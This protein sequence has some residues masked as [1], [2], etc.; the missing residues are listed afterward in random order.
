MLSAGLDGTD[1]FILLYPTNG[2][3]SMNLSCIFRTCEEKAETTESWD[4]DGDMGEMLEI[5]GD[6]DENVTKLFK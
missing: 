3:E 4:A 2:L 6:F 1:R 5:F